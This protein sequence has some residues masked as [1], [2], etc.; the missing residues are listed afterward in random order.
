MTIKRQQR[1]VERTPKEQARL[2]AIRKK[3]QQQKPGPEQ[4]VASGEYEGPV[5]GGAYWEVRRVMAE[6]GGWRGP[7]NLEF[8]RHARTGQFYLLE[9]NC[10]L[11]GYSYLFTMNGLNF[12]AAVVDLLV[13]GETPFLQLP[14]GGLRH[15]FVIGFREQPREDWVRVAS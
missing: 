12:P 9:V 1:K 7:V 10:R 6:L 15:N 11:N 4:L 13:S 14:A 3:Y 8:K 5:Q 2:D